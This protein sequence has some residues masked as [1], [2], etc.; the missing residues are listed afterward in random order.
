MPPKGSKIGG[1][2][3]RKRKLAQ[4]QP[5]S[6]FLTKGDIR[7]IARRG[8]VKRI[9]SDVYPEMFESILSLLEILIKDSLIYT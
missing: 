5:K 7:R 3:K 9:A 4:G 2:P 6:A 1:I 8:G